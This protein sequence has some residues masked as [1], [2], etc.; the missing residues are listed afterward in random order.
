MRQQ[1]NHCKPILA[2]G[3]GADVLKKLGVQVKLPSGQGDP[4]LWIVDAGG[5]TPALA[6]FKA[7][8]GAHRNFQREAEGSMV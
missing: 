2:I 1:Y 8:L 3:A 4:S 6:E 5:V 7:A